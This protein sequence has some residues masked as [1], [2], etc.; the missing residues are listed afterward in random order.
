M[1]DKALCAVLPKGRQSAPPVMI[2]NRSTVLVFDFWHFWHFDDLRSRM[3]VHGQ[4]QT[5]KQTREVLLFMMLTS[6]GG[7][8]LLTLVPPRVV[9]ALPVQCAPGVHDSYSVKCAAP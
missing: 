9:H 2:S 3:P 7:G 6:M 5:T 8:G 4:R 1:Q